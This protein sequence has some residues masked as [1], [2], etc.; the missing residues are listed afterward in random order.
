MTTLRS[1]A[2]ILVAFVLALINLAKRAANPAIDVLASD[3]NP[4]DSLLDEAP[5]GS[6][7]APGV[8]V[9]RMA[10]PLFFANGEVFSRA[11]RA[12]ITAA[13]RD[14]VHHVVLDL[15]AITDVDVT[16]AE[17][18]EGLRESLQNQGISLAFSRMR[19]T[20]RPR[21]ERLGIL[22]SDPVFPTNRAAVAA[23]T[24]TGPQEDGTIG[25]SR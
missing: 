19:P 9:I 25:G 11:V 21:L 8:V 20:A 13:G 22:R 2:G 3:D 17:S 12:A 24:A 18:F 6:V 5:T 15:E 4:A 16:G 23:L 7:T 1:I 14:A 10:A